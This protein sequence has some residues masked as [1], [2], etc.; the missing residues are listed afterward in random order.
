MMK[1]LN[2]IDSPIG[3]LGLVQEEDCLTE[4]FFGKSESHQDYSQEETLLLK[5]AKKQLKAYFEGNQK[6]FDLPLNPKGTDFQKAVWQALL[7]IPY[8]ETRSYK[9]I[10]AAIGS[11]KASRAV[12]MANNKNPL[13]ILVPCHRVI[14]SSGKL[15]GYG[16]GLTIKENLL[17]LEKDNK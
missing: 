16:G 3:I 13:S 8:G 7:L 11:P 14:G 17:G 5:E 15:V 2:Y 12:G 6:I 9:D 4:V 10:A 1:Y